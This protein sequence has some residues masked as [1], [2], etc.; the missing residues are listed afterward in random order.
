MGPLRILVVDDYREIR[1]GVGALLSSQAG[2]LICG[3]AE[4]GIDA[5]AK[6]RNLRPDVILMDVAMPRM[7]GIEATRIL[8]RELPESKVVLVSQNGRSIVSR[9][10]QDAGASAFVAK[11]DLAHELISTV[12]EIA[13]RRGFAAISNVGDDMRRDTS[14]KVLLSKIRAIMPRL[15]RINTH[16]VTGSN[17]RKTKTR[18]LTCLDRDR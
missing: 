16:Y 4:D 8:S 17:R 7:D 10:A 2:W 9:Q 5:L 6:A 14:L 1:K 13:A 3:E 11:S 12:K 18:R 15:G